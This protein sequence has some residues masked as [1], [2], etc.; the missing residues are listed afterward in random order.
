MKTALLITILTII[1]M[2]AGQTKADII[3]DYTDRQLVTDYNEPGIIKKTSTKLINSDLGDLTRT[4]VLNTPYTKTGQSSILL[5]HGKMIYTLNPGAR[6]SLIYD[7]NNANLQNYDGILISKPEGGTGT[8][9]LITNG[10]SG[11]SKSPV[12]NVNEA[13]IYASLANFTGS[14]N[15]INLTRVRANLSAGSYHGPVT[16]ELLRTAPV[17]VPAAAW[18]FLGGLLALIKLSKN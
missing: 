5:D 18:L 8:L 14:L 15:Y 10:P 4:L 1:A 6:A 16:I 7:F 13:N 12:F 9:Q 11:R 2:T 3:D 17:P